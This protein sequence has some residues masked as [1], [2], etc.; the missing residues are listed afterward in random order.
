[1][2]SIQSS[3]GAASSAASF[4]QTRTRHAKEINYVS[5]FSYHV[6]S[7]VY[8]NAALVLGSSVILVGGFLFCSKRARRTAFQLFR[9]ENSR[10]QQITTAAA[11]S[12][13]NYGALE[14]AEEVDEAI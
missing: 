1:M 10:E 3:K 9:S 4:S 2:K 6:L 7:S 8:N 11:S 14:N 13:G 12:E 5:T